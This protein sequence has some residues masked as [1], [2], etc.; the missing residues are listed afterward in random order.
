MNSLANMALKKVQ[1]LDKACVKTLL[2]L[3]QTERERT[4]LRYVITK[5]S[6]LSSRKLYGFENMSKR[7][8]EAIKAIQDVREAIDELAC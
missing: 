6:D 5:A 3:G 4:C 1:P 8:N 7:I 2:S